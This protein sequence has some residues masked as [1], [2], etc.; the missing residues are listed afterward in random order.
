ML[1]LQKSMLTSSGTQNQEYFFTA[2]YC[3]QEDRE[4][5]NLKSDI[6]GAL[7]NA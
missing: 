5:E 3:N 2:Y 1:E 7:I 6:A 4:C